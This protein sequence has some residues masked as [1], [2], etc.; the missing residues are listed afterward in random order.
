MGASAHYCH[1][2]NNHNGRQGCPVDGPLL[3]DY[4]FILVGEEGY[5]I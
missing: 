5:V 3:Q 4:D 1:G 2:I